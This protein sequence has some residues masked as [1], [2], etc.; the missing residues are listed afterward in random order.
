MHQENTK[1]VSAIDQISSFI[2]SYRGRL[3]K[4]YLPRRRGKSAW[5]TSSSQS[6]LL[7]QWQLRHAGG[8]G[9]DNLLGISSSSSLRVTSNPP[10]NITYASDCNTGVSLSIAE[11]VVGYELAW[12]KWYILTLWGTGVNI[13]II[14]H[15]FN[16]SNEKRYGLFLKMGCYKLQ[17]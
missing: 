12:Q 1:K 5:R 15:E 6:A 9:S 3:H 10:A 7:L 2:T 16:F 13:F 4:Y 8:M 17:N 14:L 11:Y